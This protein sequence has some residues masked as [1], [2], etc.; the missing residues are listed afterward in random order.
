MLYVST[1]IAFIRSKSHIASTTKHL[2][3]IFDGVWSY[4]TFI[5]NI[6]NISIVFEDG[7]DRYK[8]GDNFHGGCGFVYMNLM[9]YHLFWKRKREEKK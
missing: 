6:K 4:L 1:T 7:F 5:L 3:Y 2:F 9:D 8:S